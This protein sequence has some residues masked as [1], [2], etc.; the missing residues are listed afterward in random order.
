MKLSEHSQNRLLHSFSLWEVPQE[1]CQPV[2]DYLV[3]GWDPGSFYTAVLAND[4]MSAVTRSHPG[5]HI[6]IL[7]RLAGWVLNVMPAAAWGS[8]DRVQTWLNMN[9]E[10]RRAVLEQAK[11]IYDTKTEMWLLLKNEETVN[12]SVNPYEWAVE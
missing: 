7:K 8:Y 3:N 4:F 10:D 11:L 5:N 9:D 1:Y 12:P 2:R 6:D